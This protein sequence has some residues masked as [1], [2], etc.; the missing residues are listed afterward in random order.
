MNKKT[1]IFII[2]IFYILAISFLVSAQSSA[3]DNLLQGTSKII[4]SIYKE[5]IT[6][7]AAF[8]IGGNA[9]QEPKNFFSL[10]LLFVLLFSVLWEIAERIPLLNNNSW[11]QFIV[12]LAISVISVRFI[13]EGNNSA[14]FHSILLPNQVLGIAILSLLPLIFY[15][16]FVQDIGQGRP[17]LRKIL[18]IFAGVLFLFLYFARYSELSGGGGWFEN[19]A[20]IYFF[21]ALLSFSLLL[22]DGTIARYWHQGIA[23]AALSA[24]HSRLA[25]MIEREI[26]QLDD[27]WAN[28]RIVNARGQPDVRKYRQERDA[29][30]Q[31]LLQLRTGP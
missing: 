11:V 17:T 12:S 8:L 30:M 27:D 24:G 13:A 28:G 3:V 1:G 14:W 23:N 6:P 21:A 9:S 16:V 15:V 2:C 7:M 10:I 29:L 25:R 31:R 5:G 18:Y 4:E 19:P 20:D 22:L 26:A